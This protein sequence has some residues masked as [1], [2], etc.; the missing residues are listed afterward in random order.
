[1]AVK[2]NVLAAGSTSVDVEEELGNLLNSTA[3]Y[4]DDADG[5]TAHRSAGRPPHHIVR[6]KHQKRS[7]EGVA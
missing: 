3:S 5:A 4:A 2:Y 1:M 6:R 7:T